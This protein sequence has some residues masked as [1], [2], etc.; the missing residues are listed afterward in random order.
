MCGFAGE[1]LLR[2]GRA[3][4]DLARAMARRLAHRGPDEESAFISPDGRCAI[5][6]Q[7]LAV[8]D[9]PGSHQPISSRD[10]QVTLAF[11]GEIYNFRQ[12]RQQLVAQGVTFRTA[13]DAEVLL[14]LYRR[15]G[16]GM[17]DRL[18][19]MFAFAI[20]DQSR[21]E[22]LLARDRMGEKPLWYCVLPDRIVFASEAKALLAH[23][24]V[25]PK[26]RADSLVFYLSFGYVPAP[27][28]IWEGVDKLLP[29]HYLVAGQAVAEPQRYWSPCDLGTG[30]ANEAEPVPFE[31]VPFSAA[32]P[33]SLADSIDRIR[34]QVRRSVIQCMEA[35]VPL[36]ALL[37]GG[38]DSAVVVAVMSC[39]AGSC[40]GVRTFTAGFGSAGFD[41]RPAAAAIARHFRTDHTELL[42][43]PGGA[44]GMLDTVVAMFDEPFA[45]SSALPTHLIC[46]QARRHVTVALAGDGGDEVFA[47]YDRYRAMHAAANFGPG[48]YLAARV[49]GM[50]ARPLAGRDERGRLRRFVRFADAL[51]HPAAIQYCMYRRMFSPEDLGRLMGRDV[52][53]QLDAGAAQDWFCDLYEQPEDLPDELARAQCHDMMTY[54]SDDLLVKTDRASMA[55]SLELR[56]PLLD[57]KLVE[58]G[59]SL[60]AEMKIR[61]DRGKWILREAFRDV[62]PAGVLERPKRGFAVPLGDWLRGEL[63]PVMRQTLLNG[64]IA[65]S[66][67]LNMESV[68][69]L[70]NDHLSGRDD[71]RH[72]LWALLVLAKWF[73]RQ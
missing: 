9:L 69:G 28:S 19:G 33:P 22:L 62:L 32:A 56:S 47:G 70:I 67:L 49:A 61:R 13:G 55:C 21:G 26:M 48:R 10:G 38:I 5:G 51:G 37:S 39:A 27:R 66:G 7:R 72:R 41:E 53:A 8:I 4:I 17:F 20:Y 54:L 50:L 52:L 58:L 3:D 44:A 46:Q 29:A 60:P 65:D 68:A 1:F 15:D 63:V 25:R 71:H 6:F 2:P 16:L 57:H 31:P 24:V 11:N 34:Q 73:D 43:E 36:G 64:K 35:D 42:V 23:P 45:D 30:T 14:E 12:L 59:L 18:T 40:G